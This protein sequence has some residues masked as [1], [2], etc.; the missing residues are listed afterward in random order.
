MA[1]TLTDGTTTVILSS[2]LRWSDEHN[3]WPVEQ[4][5]KRSLSG[6]L[7]VQAQSRVG[8]RPITL[9]AQD[10]SSAW[11]SRA[12]IEQLRTWASTPGQILTLLL[13]G[14]TYSV[15]FRHHDGAG[16]EASP[17]I[18][19]SDPGPNDPYRL[20]LRLMQI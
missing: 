1:T 8:G 14:T 5:I 16:I 19:Y 11:H 6:A 2:D 13:L 17:I 10:D 12:T 3:W 15:M 9:E 20:T 4:S 7:I 18:D